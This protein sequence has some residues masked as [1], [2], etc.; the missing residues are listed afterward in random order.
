MH[1]TLEL[2]EHMKR[3][4]DL[5]GRFHEA[6]TGMKECIRQ[7][8]WDGLESV[9]SELSLLA[10]ELVET[11][12]ARHLAFEELR[13]AVGEAFSAPFYQV[14]VHL[15]PEE[16]DRLAE[17]YR[18]M[19]F[20]VFGIRADSYCMDDQIRSINETIHDVLGELYPHRKGNLYSSSGA[21]LSGGANPLILDE[22]M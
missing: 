12:E 1:S 6:E 10:D 14:V 18:L 16:R 7:K 11:E 9:M 21:R 22:Q 15:P 17:L 20:S 2:S 8:D 13:G 3:E 5:L 4:A 19:K